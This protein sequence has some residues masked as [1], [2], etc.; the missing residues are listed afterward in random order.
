VG[1]QLPHGLREVLPRYLL[2]RGHRGARGSH[3]A[4]GENQTLSTTRDKRARIN[5][6]GKRGD[7]PVERERVGAAAARG[8]GLR[9]VAMRRRAVG[10]AFGV[11]EPNARLP[12]SGVAGRTKLGSG[13]QKSWA[14][15][16]R[17]L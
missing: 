8:E 10:I 15:A 3:G 13:E 16:H 9:G 17:R 4:S 11:A 2:R 5:G 1:P 6:G 14:V 7:R 12:V